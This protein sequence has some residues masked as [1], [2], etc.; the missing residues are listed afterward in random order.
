MRSAQSGGGTEG[1]RRGRLHGEPHLHGRCQGLGKARGGQGLSLVARARLEV[2]E[3]P[4]GE[5]A[6]VQRADQQAPVFPRFVRGGARV[7]RQQVTLEDAFVD[8]HV[9]DELECGHGGD[10]GGHEGDVPAHVTEPRVDEGV[11]HRAAGGV[12]GRLPRHAGRPLPIK[13][14]VSRRHLD[15]AHEKVESVE[16]MMGAIVVVGDESQPR[17]N[18][19]GQEGIVEA[20]AVLRKEVRRV[21]RA[22]V[23]L[24]DQPR[25]QRDVALTCHTIVESHGNLLVPP[26]NA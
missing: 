12:R 1:E 7:T 10:H 17:A 13:A 18:E 22:R 4:F 5:Q 21:R 2:N 11:A 25:L 26:L 6:G 8:A 9:G 14:L 23:Q 16:P 3:R 15:V 19:H 24:A 20:L